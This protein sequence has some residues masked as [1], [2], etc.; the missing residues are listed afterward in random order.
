MT[1]QAKD[2]ESIFGAAIQIPSSDDRAAFL[3]E[4]CGGDRQLRAEVE[5]LVIDHFRAG[6]FLEQPAVQVDASTATPWSAEPIGNRIG[7]YK[8]LQEIGEG[9]M[10]TVCSSPSRLQPVKRRVAVKIIKHGHGHAP[11]RRPF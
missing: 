5:K 4:A 1:D 8:L 9:G 3:N 10:G 11:V 6:S 7:P 2:A